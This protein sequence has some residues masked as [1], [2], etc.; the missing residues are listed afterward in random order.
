M[1]SSDAGDAPSAES[2]IKDRRCRLVASG[3][4]RLQP[5]GLR[6]PEP[7]RGFRACWLEYR[8][9]MW[10]MSPRRTIW[11]RAFREKQERK[12]GRRLRVAPEAA[13][14][15]ATLLDALALVLALGIDV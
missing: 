2:S 3:P 11:L 12:T 13:T 4:P 14:Q 8:D 9:I 7:E 15:I 1:E 6:S 10:Q 5:L